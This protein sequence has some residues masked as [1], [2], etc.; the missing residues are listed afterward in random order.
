MKDE[1][2]EVMKEV[3]LTT[4]EHGSAA[5]SQNRLKNVLSLWKKCLEEPMN[6]PE[7]HFNQDVQSVVSQDTIFEDLDVFM[8]NDLDAQRSYLQYEILL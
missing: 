6:Y 4:D 1:T 7:S 8:C 5:Y 2:V 3:L